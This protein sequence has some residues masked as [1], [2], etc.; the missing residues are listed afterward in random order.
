MHIKIHCRF[1]NIFLK[2][3]RIGGVFSRTV[4][5]N[6]GMEKY[7]VLMSVYH[8]DRP[9]YLLAAARSVLGQ[10]FLPAQFVLVKDGPLGGALEK[11]VED[12]RDLCQEAGCEFTPVAIE[13]N[14]GLGPA[15]NLGLGFCREE[16]VARMDAD[17][18]SL[19][20][21]CEKQ[22][23]FMEE[24]PDTVLL[25]GV[26]VEFESPAPSFDSIPKELTRKR[27]PL[28][29]EEIRRT[30]PSRNPMNHPCVMFRR[31]A[32]AA[33]GGY[34]SVPLFEDYDL[35]L[36]ILF[37]SADRNAKAANLPDE[38]LL[39]RTDGMYERRGGLAYVKNI[40]S[41]RRQMFRDGYLSYPSYL[42]STSARSAVGLLPGSLR[43]RIY[44]RFLR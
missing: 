35:W 14:G 44:N 17:D 27:V 13:K 28:T 6:E 15:L 5:Y 39:M 22:V 2:I 10:T 3:T 38:L 34:R 18:L 43:K 31:M 40:C 11:T 36:R 41:F 25:S 32:V 19:P 26:I 1:Y 7:C 9:E 12:I 42:F 21:R 24:H 20:D 16:L 37:A 33:A 4:L 8:K 30:A 29:D 23:R